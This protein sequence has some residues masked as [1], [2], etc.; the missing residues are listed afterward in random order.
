MK[1]LYYTSSGIYPQ[2]FPPQLSGWT[3]QPVCGYRVLVKTCGSGSRHRIIVHSSGQWSQACLLGGQYGSRRSAVSFFP[4]RDSVLRTL[5]VFKR[6]YIFR[7]CC[8]GNW[9]VGEV[10]L[11]GNQDFSQ[12]H[13]T[14]LHMAGSYQVF[15]T[16]DMRRD[17]IPRRPTARHPILSPQNVYQAGAGNQW[18]T[19]PHGQHFHMVPP[20]WV[21]SVWYNHSLTSTSYRTEHPV[22]SSTGSG[23]ESFLTT[24]C[25]TYFPSPYCSKLLVHLVP[26]VGLDRKQ[27]GF[28]PS[29]LLAIFSPKAL[30]L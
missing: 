30:Y 16:L 20:A 18:Q 25:S 9:S 6:P 10:A 7:D 29:G 1:S 12:Y 27:P 17:I 11:R 13:A 4:H 28:V 24:V 22:H 8:S 26:L 2:S 23:N 14:S 3:Q 19:S 15:L 5:P 21:M